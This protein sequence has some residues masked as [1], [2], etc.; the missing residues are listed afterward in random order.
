MSND[1]VEQRIDQLESI[2]FT[3]NVQEDKVNYV[4][5]EVKINSILILCASTKEW[6]NFIITNK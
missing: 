4:K 3:L 5:G 2:G 6:E 1:I